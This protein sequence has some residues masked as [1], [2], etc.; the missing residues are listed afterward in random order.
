MSVIGAVVKPALYYVGRK[1]HLLELLALSG[2]PNEEAGSRLIVARTGGTSHCGADANSSGINNDDI[3]LMTFKLRDVQEGKS[4]LWMK[5]G[6]V[7][8]VLEA[9]FVYVYGNVEKPGQIKMREPI[10]LTQAIA[11]S[12]GLKSATDKDKVRV[13]REKGNG[14]EREELI[15]DLAAIEKGKAKDPYL[16]PSDIVAISR[17]KAKSILLAVT[18]AIKGGIPSAIARGVPVP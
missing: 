14:E 5:P 9:D 17:D 18:D 13:L 6:D 2:G 12:L 10:T 15:F 7:V 8:S 11:T 4:T 3:A 1:V 16:E